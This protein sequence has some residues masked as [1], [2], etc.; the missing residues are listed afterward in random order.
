MLKTVVSALLAA[1]CSALAE[2]PDPMALQ[3]GEVSSNGSMYEEMS[4]MS[5]MTNAASALEAKMR[6]QLETGECQKVESTRNDKQPPGKAN[7]GIF[8]RPWTKEMTNLRDGQVYRDISDTMSA[9]FTLTSHDTPVEEW[10]MKPATMPPVPGAD[11]KMAFLFFANDRIDNE[12]IWL[13]WM[14]EVPEKGWATCAHVPPCFPIVLFLSLLPPSPWS[15][16][17]LPPFDAIVSHSAEV[18]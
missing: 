14:D 6:A 13:H 8:N 10:G 9:C 12:E 4:A 1:H 18:S 15:L 5:A 16:L 11:V 17:Q 3:R 7:A 2:Q